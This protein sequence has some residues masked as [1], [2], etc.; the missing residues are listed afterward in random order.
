M[1]MNKYIIK[2]IDGKQSLYGPIYAL[3]CIKLEMLK[4]YIKTHLKTGFIQPSK[5]LAR[6]S[7]L[8]DKKPN[9]SLCLHINY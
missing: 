1:G 9:G 4:T 5:F 2:L 8:F 3:S 6:A 7:I